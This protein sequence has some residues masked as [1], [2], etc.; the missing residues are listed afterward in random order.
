MKTAKS[1]LFQ[2]EKTA[3][4]WLSAIDHYSEEQFIKKRDADTWSVGQIYNHLVNGTLSYTLQQVEQCLDGSKTER[5]GS[6]TLPG[7]LTF[8]LQSFPPIRI[9]VPPSEIYTPKQPENIEVM[10]TG[11]EKL[12]VKMRETE[13]KLSGAGETRK[14]AHPAFGFLNA[15]EWF[16][17]IEMHFRHHLRQK[18]R[19]DNFLASL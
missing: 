13:K 6:K 1:I 12:I 16:Q 8:M 15:R 5:N 11:L 3:K 17:L 10:S 18:K 7:K 14:T 4:I 19:L 9:K 2:F